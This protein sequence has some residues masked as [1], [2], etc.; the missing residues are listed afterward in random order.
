MHQ[1]RIYCVNEEGGF[2]SAKEVYAASDAEA[3]AQ[4]RAL[5][6]PGICEVWQ[7]DRLVAKIEAHASA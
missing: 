1:Y 4:A 2:S 3:I 7:K 5:E 6:H